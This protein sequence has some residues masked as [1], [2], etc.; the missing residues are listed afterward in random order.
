MNKISYRGYRFPPR[1][2]SKRMALPPVHAQPA[3]RRK[4]YCAERGVAVSYE[5]VRRWVNH[6]DVTDNLRS[7][8]AAVRELGISAGMSAGDGRTIGL[9]IRIG[10]HGG[11]SARCSG[12]RARFSPEISFHTR[13]RLQHLQRPTPP[14][15]RPHAPRASRCRDDHVADRSRSG[16]TFLWCRHFA[17]AARQRDKAAGAVA[18]KRGHRRQHRRR[19]LAHRAGHGPLSARGA[20]SAARR[21]DRRPLSKGRARS[22]KHGCARHRG[23]VMERLSFVDAL[24]LYMET[25]ETPMHIASVTIFKPVSPRDDFF[26]RF[27][28]HVA[29]RLDLLPSYRR[30]L[31]R[32][33]SASTIRPGSSKTSWTST[34][35][36]VT[37]PCRSPAA[38]R[39]CGP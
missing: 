5:T 28:E 30:R 32:R 25:P 17:P 16:L 33:R 35:T 36:S 6:S 31:E 27:R 14:R 4:I 39:N 15:L 3:Q 29:A 1:S 2:F 37:R 12:S 7:Y 11:G 23:F 38:W 34:T 26:A 24:F 19:A 8:G 10:R 18:R 20:R 9:R 13:R 22:A 21:R